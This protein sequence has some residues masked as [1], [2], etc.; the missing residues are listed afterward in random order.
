MASNGQE[1]DQ[2]G[3]TGTD[4]NVGIVDQTPATV[5]YQCP[6]LAFVSKMSLEMCQHRSQSAHMRGND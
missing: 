3:L 2:I 5:P 1:K 4:W 6:V